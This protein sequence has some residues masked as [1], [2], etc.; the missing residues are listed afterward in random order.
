MHFAL[1]L[2]DAGAKIQQHRVYPLLL[3][4]EIGSLDDFGIAKLFAA[5]RAMRLPRRPPLRHEVNRCG[6]IFTSVM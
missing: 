3:T 4:F 5:R 2:W 6:A 1:C